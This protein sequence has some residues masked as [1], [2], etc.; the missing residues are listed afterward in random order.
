MTDKHYEGGRNIETPSDVIAEQAIT[1]LTFDPQHFTQ[2]IE[3]LA[4]D[5]KQAEALLESL[6]HIMAGFVDLGWGVDSVQLL[7]PDM[8]ESVAEDSIHLLQSTLDD[9]TEDKQT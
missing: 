8:F 2:E 6:W 7:L 3:D 4:I 5:P 1:S 9:Q